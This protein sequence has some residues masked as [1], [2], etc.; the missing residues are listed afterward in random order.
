M[1]F[2]QGACTVVSTPNKIGK[3]KKEKKKKTKKY[4]EDRGVLGDELG[5]RHSSFKLDFSGY[6]GWGYRR[7]LCVLCIKF[8]AKDKKKKKKKRLR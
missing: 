2:S 6:S 3:S 4:A 5:E 8:A 7:V 1:S